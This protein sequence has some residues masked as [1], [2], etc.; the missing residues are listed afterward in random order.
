MDLTGTPCLGNSFKNKSNYDAAETPDYLTTGFPCPDYSR[1][2]DHTGDSGST[3]W[4]FVQQA[5]LIL[6]I[7]AKTTRLEMSDYAIEVNNGREVQDVVSQLST[8]YHLY[9]AIIPV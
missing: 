8:I 3:G 7:K 5:A 1:S 6:R 4:M 2:G 9:A